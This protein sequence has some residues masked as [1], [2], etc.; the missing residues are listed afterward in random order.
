MCVYSVGSLDDPLEAA[1]DEQGQE[2]WE[3]DLRDQI[4]EIV[5]RKRS[6]IQGREDYLTAYVRILSMHYAGEE[7]EGR[8][9]EL[10]PALSKSIKSESSEKE[11][12]LAIKAVALTA[13]NLPHSGIYDGFQRIFRTMISNSVYMSVKAA[14]IHGLGTV[15][16]FGGAGEDDMLDQMDFLLEIVSSDGHHISAYDD[17]ECVTAALEE[18]GFLATKIWDLESESNDAVEVFLEQLDSAEDSVLVAAGENIA[19]LYEKSY[20]KPKESHFTRDSLDGVEDS[21]SDDDEDDDVGDEASIPDTSTPN[22]QEDVVSD[23]DLKQSYEPYHNTRAV[24]SKMTEISR[25]GGRHVSKRSKKSLHSNFTSIITSIK[26]PRRGPN[27]ST[28]IDPTTEHYKG[29]RGNLKISSPSAGEGEM[30]I[31][32]WWKAIRL[33]ALR[34]VLRGGFVSHYFE[35]NRAV[36]DTLPV[37]MVGFQNKGM[38][39]KKK[40]GLSSKGA[41]RDGGGGGRRVK[42]YDKYYD[43]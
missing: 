11:T 28:A 5:D 16:Y 4:G 25:I 24:I 9:D 1:E 27:Y 10:F 29:S 37:I 26:N 22:D 40:K 19:L 8:T 20:I 3:S 18:W 2:F 43:D 35:G 31:D 41:R 30:R 14:A 38:P 39:G 17:A 21:E 32:R 15:A 23:P 42:M 13:V 36:L 12:I 34:R 33:A 7:L 6:S